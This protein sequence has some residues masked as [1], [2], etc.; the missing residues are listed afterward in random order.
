MEVRFENGWIGRAWLFDPRAPRLFR[1]SDTT[2]RQMVPPVDVIED[3]DTYHFYFEMPGLTNRSIDARV[4]DGHLLVEAERTRPEWPQAAK[5]QIA[6]RGYG[7]FH[8]AFELPHDASRDRIEASYKDG[9]LDVTVEK[10][11]EAKPAKILIN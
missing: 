10:M 3:N 11:P 8:R 5:V 4:E 1:A 2:P 9:V 6:E 7:K